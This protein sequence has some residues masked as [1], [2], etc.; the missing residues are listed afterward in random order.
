[1][2]VNGQPTIDD[3]DNDHMYSSVFDKFCE[4]VMICVKTAVLIKINTMASHIVR[5][6]D[7]LLYVQVH[8]VSE[9]HP[10][11]LLAIS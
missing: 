5:N 3:A 6:S 4:L 8:R 10:L 1:M 9:K 7:L 2:I 11:V